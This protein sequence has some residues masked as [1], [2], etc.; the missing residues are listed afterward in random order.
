MDV[1]E[2][3]S[4]QP[5]ANGALQHCR[6]HAHRSSL[7]RSLFRMRYYSTL[8]LRFYSDASDALDTNYLVNDNTIE[9]RRKSI[10]IIDSNGIE[11]LAQIKC[12]R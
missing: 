3:F 11:P 6:N 5:F 2:S 1:A 4:P 12:Q 9:I 8:I 7:S 10:R